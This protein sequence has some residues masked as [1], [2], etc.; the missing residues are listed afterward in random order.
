MDGSFAIQA[1]ALEFIAKK[2]KNFENKVIDLPAEYDDY[3]A[4]MALESHNIHLQPLTEEQKEYLTG[5]DE[6]T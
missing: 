6:G 4:R 2:G 3:V 5:F 1:L